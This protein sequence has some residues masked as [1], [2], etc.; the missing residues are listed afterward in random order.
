MNNKLSEGYQ[1]I[2][3]CKAYAH[4]LFESLQTLIDAR[5][6]LNWARNRSISKVDLSPGQGRL[7]QT[8]NH[9]GEDHHSWW[10]EP[11][12]F[13]PNASVVDVVP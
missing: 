3:N 7:L 13:I 2:N 10:P 1:D 8:P 6:F 12:H 4:S 5:D 11:L 9:I